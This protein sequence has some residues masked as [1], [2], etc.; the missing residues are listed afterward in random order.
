M[1]SAATTG[2]GLLTAPDAAPGQPGTWRP[3]GASERVILEGPGLGE[4]L[5]AVLEHSFEFHGV[6]AVHD[7]VE[8]R[9]PVADHPVRHGLGVKIGSEMAARGRQ[10]RHGLY[11]EK[12]LPQPQLFTT[13]GLLNL[14]PR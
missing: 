5:G 10:V 8:L 3:A 13:F 11:A 12:L 1:P 6:C 14:N 4:D 7:E 2:M 9:A